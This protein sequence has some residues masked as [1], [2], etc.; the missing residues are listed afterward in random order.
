MEVTEFGIETDRRAVQFLKVSYSI[1]VTLG[2]MATEVRPL[3]AKALSPIE[4]T[5]DGIVIEVRFLHPL[6]VA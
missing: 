3:F 2:G 1:D 4:V 6:K 5:E